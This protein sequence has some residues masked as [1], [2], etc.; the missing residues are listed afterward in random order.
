M[1]GIVSNGEG[2]CGQCPFAAHPDKLAARR[3]DPHS[4]AAGEVA[5]R[6]RRHRP[7]DRL[8]VVEHQQHLTVSQ[9]VFERVGHR[10]IRRRRQLQRGSHQR[11]DPFA[12]PRHRETYEPHPVSKRCQRAGGRLQRQSC[13][14]AP[15]RSRQ[16]DEP[17]VLERVEHLGELVSTPN[18]R[19]ER[20]GQI[21]RSRQGAQRRELALK[22]RVREL[23]D[24]D[25][26]DVLQ[27]VTAEVYSD[28]VGREPVRHLADEHL[29]AVAD[30]HQPRRPIQLGAVIVTI[31]HPRL[32]RVHTHAHLDHHTLHAAALP[33]APAAPP[34]LPA[35]RHEQYRTRRGTRP[36]W[37]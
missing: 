35:T 16:G 30:R 31:T 9:P 18:E 22:R 27:M 4:S 26:T 36:P 17:A 15:S 11:D 32:A 23:P 13:L 37:S 12:G 24:T 5:L 19:V 3:Q 14:A 1:R 6:K 10:R 25:L 20:R 8:T 33:P 7:H 2:R 29:T 28:D 21:V 34:M